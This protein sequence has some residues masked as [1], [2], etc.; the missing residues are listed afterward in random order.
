MLAVWFWWVWR[1]WR[2]GVR[3]G[4]E[5]KQ[6]GKRPW[7][8]GRRLTSTGD[9]SK[10]TSE[11]FL[12]RPRPSSN[13]ACCSS[14]AWLVLPLALCS[15]PSGAAAT[16]S[17]ASK[18]MDVTQFSRASSEVAMVYHYAHSSA[19]ALLCLLDDTPARV[20]QKGSQA[21]T[22][23]MA[24]TQRAVLSWPGRHEV[25]VAVVSGRWQ[26]AV[27]VVPCEKED[28]AQPTQP[29]PKQQNKR[30]ARCVLELS[31]WLKA[32]KAL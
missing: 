32:A 4:R 31:C 19:G 5:R 3:S 11:A 24:W 20:G 16:C 15:P 23:R 10:P 12:P 26:V 8:G 22:H 7:R 17:G 27:L 13:A 2:D 18:A 30:I 29:P 9:D 6:R 25:A 1:W 14:S 21:S 28:G